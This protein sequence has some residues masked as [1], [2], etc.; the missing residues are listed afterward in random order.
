MDS[1]WGPNPLSGV[2]LRGGFGYSSRHE[3]YI[4]AEKAQTSTYARLSRAH[5]NGRRAQHAPAPPQE[6]PQAPFGVI[7]KK[8]R[9]PRVV[10]KTSVGGPSRVFPGRFLSLS[11]TSPS[12]SPAR[13]SCVVSKQVLKQAHERNF[14]KRRL[15]AIASSHLGEVRRGVL[16]LRAKKSAGGVSFTE[17]KRDAEGLFAQLKGVA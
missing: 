13:I 4:S 16:F 3:T 15:R 14:L 17:L 2:V 5:A 1:V 12:H 6:G 8:H 7:P 11:F 9:L 10:A